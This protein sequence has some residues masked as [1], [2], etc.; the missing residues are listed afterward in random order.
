MG[1]SWIIGCQENNSAE[2]E[3]GLR[4]E[5]RARAQRD[6]RRMRATRGQRRTGSATGATGF[7]PARA[8]GRLA[9]GVERIGVVSTG[10]STAEPRS[11]AKTR[12]PKRQYAH[13]K[14]EACWPLRSLRAA[15]RPLLQNAAPDRMLLPLLL[16]RCRG[17]QRCRERVQ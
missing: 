15:E 11:R 10:M 13:S 1:R 3:I 17:L 9:F 16:Q 2:P 14:L 12:R 5:A 4:Y 7:Q 6:P 8:L